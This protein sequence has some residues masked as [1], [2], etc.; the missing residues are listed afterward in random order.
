M[1]YDEEKPEDLCYTIHLGRG[2][3]I[4]IKG[5]KGTTRKT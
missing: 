5:G 1:Y 2:D 3:Q 4:K